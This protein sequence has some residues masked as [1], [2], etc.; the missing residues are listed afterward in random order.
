M[1]GSVVSGIGWITSR[2]PGRGREAR[3]FSMTPGPIPPVTREEVF[4]EPNLRFGRLPHY[5]RVGLAAVAFALRDAGME[6]WETKRSAGIVASTRA[7]CLLTDIEYYRTVLPEGGGVPS[8][9]LFSSTLPTCFLGEA[10]IQFGLTGPTLVVNDPG[11][12]AMGGVRMALESLSWGECGTM[13]AGHIDLPAAPAIPGI[14]TPHAGG[15]FL[16][17]ENALDPSAGGYGALDLSEG[18]AVRHEGIE[19]DDLNELVRACLAFP[20]PS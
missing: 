16:V 13:L 4:P 20:R 3:E 9:N 11:G 10:A 2:G 18:G 5:S 12:D 15:V 14:R 17:L 19:I 1:T 6:H 8:P 7:G